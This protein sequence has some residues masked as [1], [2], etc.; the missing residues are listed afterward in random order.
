MVPRRHVNQ[1]SAINDRRKDLYI[2]IGTSEVTACGQPEDLVDP[3]LTTAGLQ[4]EVRPQNGI[5]THYL[6][7][8]DVRVVGV[9][10]G[11]TRSEGLIR[12]RYRHLDKSRSVVVEAELYFGHVEKLAQRPSVV[13][14]RIAVFTPFVSADAARRH[15]GELAGALFAFV[16]Y[17]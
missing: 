15:A 8:R 2:K 14:V 1:H 10:L 6:I 13:L 5:S 9:H 3:I 16:E 4:G 11:V 17:G 7:G 12:A